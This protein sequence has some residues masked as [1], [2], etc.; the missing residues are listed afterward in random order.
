[1]KQKNST[2]RTLTLS[3]LVMLLCVAMLVGTTFA[4]FTDSAST[5]VNKIQ[6]GTLDVQLLD[7]QD[8][9]LEGQT[10][11]WQK[12]AGHESDPVLW[13][14][15]CTYKL[16]PI[17]IKNNGNLALKY[18]ISLNG[19]QGNAKLLE[20]IQ[21]T[22]KVGDT[23][24]ALDQLN[25]TLLANTKSAP[26]VISGH[27][28][29]SAGN[30]YQGLSIDGIA[31]TVNATQLEHEFDSNGNDYDKE[32]VLPVNA[33]AVGN[34]TVTS[35]STQNNAEVNVAQTLSDGVMSVTYPNGVML[36]TTSAVTGD[37][38]KKTT[39]NQSLTYV[40]A[41]PSSASITIGD[42]KAVAQYELT[43]PV[44]TDNATPVTVAINY[45]KGLTGVQVYHSGVLLTATA[46]ADGESATYDAATGVLTLTLKHASPIDIVYNAVKETPVATVTFTD[47]TKKE[48]LASTTYEVADPEVTGFDDTN[49]SN[50]YKALSRAFYDVARTGGTIVINQDLTFGEN[51]ASGLEMIGD[52]TESAKKSNRFKKAESVKEVVLDLAGHSINMTYSGEDTQY[53]SSIYFANINVTI[54]DSSADK[55]GTISSHH[56]SVL[57]HLGNVVLRVEG[58][59]FLTDCVNGSLHGIGIMKGGD[60]VYDD[61]AEKYVPGQVSMTGGI[62]SYAG[63]MEE[64]NSITHKT[65]LD[66]F[67]EGNVAEGYIGTFNEETGCITVT[68]K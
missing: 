3:L 68:K 15:G 62:L 47:G 26:I 42:G 65:Y 36:N 41:T 57:C 14:P 24:T 9:S 1:M 28:K 64:A 4:W 66:T 60:F 33:T 16:Q 17:V 10:L 49:W 38:E 12:A 50:E 31:I 11:A 46:N 37:T 6:A 45:A 18:T 43:L 29:E 48:Y 25:G 2:K 40:G 22:V 52:Y 39:V 59:S 23:E 30:E 63:A 44:A 54:E 19:V 32:A 58:G 34:L 35:T 61:A 8:N 51:D 5:A 56:L 21:F 27:M 67:N 53:S 55:T 20:A 7:E 13:E